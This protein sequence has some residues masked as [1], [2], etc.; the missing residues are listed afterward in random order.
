MLFFEP[1]DFALRI[2]QECPKQIPVPQSGRKLI[3]EPNEPKNCLG[4]IYCLG[5]HVLGNLVR[6]AEV[7]QSPAGF[8][9]VLESKQNCFLMKSIAKKHKALILQQK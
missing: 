4:S 1:N 7:L 2:T 3:C 9:V 5:T 6:G 8:F